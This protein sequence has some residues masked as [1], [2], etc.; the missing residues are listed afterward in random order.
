MAFCTK[1]TCR[2][3]TLLLIS[4]I[5]TMQILNISPSVSLKI[6]IKFV[7]FLFNPSFKVALD[8]WTPLN[9]HIFIS[10]YISIQIFL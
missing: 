6:L 1:S 2:K 9:L 5:L 10:V 7:I 8:F 3:V 4:G